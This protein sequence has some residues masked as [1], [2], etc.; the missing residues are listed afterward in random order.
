ME[1]LARSLAIDPADV[2][3][4]Y[5]A[6]CTYAQ[7]GEADRAI[8]LLENLLQEPGPRFKAWFKNDSDLDAIRTHPRYGRLLELADTCTGT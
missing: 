7:L 6:A 1:W 2:I 3:T 5:N 8:D 4:R